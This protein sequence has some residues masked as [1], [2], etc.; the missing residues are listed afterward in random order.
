MRETQMAQ[1]RV[2]VDPSAFTQTI[3]ST[4]SSRRDKQDRRPTVC[5]HPVRPASLHDEAASSTVMTDALGAI[6][7]PIS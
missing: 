5:C 2:R 4:A 6:S 1:Q 7:E 3:E